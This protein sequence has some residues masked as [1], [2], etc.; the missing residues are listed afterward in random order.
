MTTKSLEDLTQYKIIRNKVNARIQQIEEE[1]LLSEVHETHRVRSEW[2]SDKSIEVE[3][4]EKKG[5][6]WKI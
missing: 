1:Y 4:N 3:I 6:R 5:N 2:S